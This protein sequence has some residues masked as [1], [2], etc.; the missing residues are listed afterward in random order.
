GRISVYT[1]GTICRIPSYNPLWQDL[2]F[3]SF[4][5]LLVFRESDEEILQLHCA[6]IEVQLVNLLKFPFTQPAE[7]HVGT[8]RPEAFCRQQFFPCCEL[9]HLLL[10]T[11]HPE[12]TFEQHIERFL[13]FHSAVMH[14]D[15]FIE[16]IVHL[17]NDM[18]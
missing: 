12:T 15:H 11:A 6:Y 1:T 16:Q 18:C 2:I 3:H 7:N 13:Q 9:S 5:T 4:H 10:R 8:D 14:D 17:G